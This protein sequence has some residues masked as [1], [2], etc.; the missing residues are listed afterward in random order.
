MLGQP[1]SKREARLLGS[2]LDAALQDPR[3]LAAEPAPPAAV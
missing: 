3:W 1:S 2:E